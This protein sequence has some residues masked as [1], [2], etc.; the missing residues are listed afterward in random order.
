MRLLSCFL[1]LLA[2]CQSKQPAE[3]TTEPDSV[4]V[5][6]TPQ[7]AYE[8]PGNNYDYRE[9]FGVYDHESTT[10]GFSA[11]LSLGQNG[12]DL[13]FTVSVV[14]GGCKGE[15][16]G[17]VL[18]LDQKQNYYAGFYESDDCRLQFTF[19]PAEK[20]VDIKEV[21]LCKLLESGCSFE[22]TYLKRSK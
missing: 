2:G 20:K 15:T 17:V 4:S 11:V 8:K 1:I 14:Q 7:D 18:M 9:L 10:N 22:G 13:Y 12:Y 3:T 6:V 19:M 16:E 21:S 5:D